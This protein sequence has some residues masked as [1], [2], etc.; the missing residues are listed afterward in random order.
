MII[1]V[2]LFTV[3]WNALTNKQNIRAVF[4][5]VCVTPLMGQKNKLATGLDQTTQCYLMHLGFPI[6]YACQLY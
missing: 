3:A 6:K 1:F 5:I 4:I 2:L